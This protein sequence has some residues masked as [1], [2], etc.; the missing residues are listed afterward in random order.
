M[1]IGELGSSDKGLRRRKSSGEYQGIRLPGG[2]ARA[3]KGRRGEGTHG[4]RHDG[5]AGALLS[6]TSGGPARRGL[7]G[8]ERAWEAVVALACVGAWV[9]R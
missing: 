5:G 3:W 2:D 1:V 7:A 4:D 9:R 6:R 8:R